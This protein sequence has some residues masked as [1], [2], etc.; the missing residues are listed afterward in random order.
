MRHLYSY[1]LR[2]KTHTRK[3][4]IRIQKQKERSEK[5]KKASTKQELYRSHDHSLLPLRRFCFQQNNGKVHSFLE[6][7]ESKLRL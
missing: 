1:N 4:I 7:K 2:Q 6:K 3:Y 5:K